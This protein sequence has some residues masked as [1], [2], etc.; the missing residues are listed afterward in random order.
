MCNDAMSPEQH[1]PTETTSRD[2]AVLAEPGLQE[3]ECRQPF[4]HLLIQE[5][6]NKGPGIHKGQEDVLDMGAHVH[7][8]PEDTLSL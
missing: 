3:S 4:R 7:K 1:N 8:E 6:S 5:R 2:R